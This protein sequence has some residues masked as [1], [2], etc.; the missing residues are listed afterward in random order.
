[1]RLL[2]RD[3]G[4]VVRFHNQLLYLADQ[5]ESEKS[6]KITVNETVER[7]RMRQANETETVGQRTNR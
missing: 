2:Y 1:M 5:M 4:T 7:Q 3:F 6:Y